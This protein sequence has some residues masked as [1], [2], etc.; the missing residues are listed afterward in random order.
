MNAAD[1][2][3]KAN[4]A[5]RCERDYD[6]EAEAFAP[7]GCEATATETVIDIEDTP[8]RFCAAHAEEARRL[9]WMLRGIMRGD[10]EAKRLQAWIYESSDRA[11]YDRRVATLPTGCA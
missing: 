2:I 6:D 7:N 5:V 1:N 3:T 11:E 8:L 10:A 4:D 9:N